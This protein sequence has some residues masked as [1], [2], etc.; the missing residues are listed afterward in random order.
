MNFLRRQ[1]TKQDPWKGD[2]PFTT[3]GRFTK[4]DKKF[5]SL[6]H[7]ETY[8][9]AAEHIKDP[10]AKNLVVDYGPDR[11][12]CALDVGEEELEE[13]SYDRPKELDSRWIAIF[14]PHRQPE[15]VA[16]LA[17]MFQLSQRHKTILLDKPR[18]PKEYNEKKGIRGYYDIVNRVYH[19]H[20]VELGGKCE[21]G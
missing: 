17:D 18:N 11:A 20:A 19:W 10:Y 15:L 21:F 12:F 2:H 6:D 14:G 1:T 3:D 9:A 4:L 5:S 16:K 7:D 13:L 8:I